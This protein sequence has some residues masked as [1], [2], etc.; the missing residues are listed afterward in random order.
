MPIRTRS[1]LAIVLAGAL[2]AGIPFNTA[3]AA[4]LD[5]A[6]FEDADMRDL[7]P[8]APPKPGGGAAH[9]PLVSL[10]P[11]STVVPVGAPISFEVGS[12]VSGFGHLY[13]ISASGRVQ[14]WMENAPIA[15]GQRLSFPAGGPGIEAAAPPGREDLMLIVTRDRIDGFFGYEGTRTPR[16]IDY[17]PEAFKR[18]LSSRLGDLPHRQWGYARA[19]VQVVARTAAAPAWGWDT[20]APKGSPDVWDRH[21]DRHWETD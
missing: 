19:S 10:R 7:R 1:T 18:E 2:A 13:V 4:D 3:H 20:G 8:A 5:D 9:R 15:A 14:V 21:W 6:G 17:R 11:S 16:L 12:S